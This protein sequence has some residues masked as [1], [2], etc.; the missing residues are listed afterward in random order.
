M[1]RAVGR[2]RSPHDPVS[3]GRAATS[4]ARAPSGDPGTTARPV[5][6]GGPVP[7]ALRTRTTLFFRRC[8]I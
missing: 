1:R 5:R 4:V 8:G 6:S 2:G 7:R 3:S